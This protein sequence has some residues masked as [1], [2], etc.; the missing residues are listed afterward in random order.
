MN[1]LRLPK[2]LPRG[3]VIIAPA[4]EA[5]INPTIKEAASN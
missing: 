2:R 1:R 5:S 4:I 3:D